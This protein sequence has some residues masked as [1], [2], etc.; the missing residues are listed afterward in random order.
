[1]TVL[2]TNIKKSDSIKE[3]YPLLFENKDNVNLGIRYEKAWQEAK[4]AADILKKEY[5]AKQVWVFGS[6]TEKNRFNKNS[7]IDL[8]EDGIPDNKFYSAISAITRAI[9][10][11]KVDLVDVRSCRDII[12]SAIEKEGVLV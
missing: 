6:L 4:L 1:M 11:F 7:D 9:K 2:F 8:A 3:K 10:D 5:G 12:K